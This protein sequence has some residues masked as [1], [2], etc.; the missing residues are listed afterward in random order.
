MGHV[1]DT[2]VSIESERQF[3]L[4]IE[5]WRLLPRNTKNNEF[6]KEILG[7]FL[8]YGAPPVPPGHDPGSEPSSM[9]SVF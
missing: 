8:F 5:H 9:S 6:V 3:L 1:G 4:R 2:G 7:V